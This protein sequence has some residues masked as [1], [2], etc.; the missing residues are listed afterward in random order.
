MTIKQL[1]KICHKIAIKKG[2]WDIKEFDNFTFDRNNGEM[3]ALIHSEL[4]EALKELREI[5]TNWKHVA[6]EMADC[7]I[8]IMDF[9]EGRNIDLQKAILKKMK[10]NEKRPYKHDKIF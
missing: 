4:S 2:F 1:Q 3:I 8:R 9:C 6:E 7:V 10:K 5:N